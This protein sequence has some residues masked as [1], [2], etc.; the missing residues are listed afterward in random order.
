MGH[1]FRNVL[2]FSVCGTHAFTHALMGVKFDMKELTC[3]LN[4]T[5]I[6]ETC[7]PCGCKT[8][9]LPLKLCASCQ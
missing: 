5:P 4:F 8:S 7:H 9:E 2:K 3:T 1:L 6:G